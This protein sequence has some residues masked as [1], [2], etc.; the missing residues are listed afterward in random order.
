MNGV[1]SN[2]FGRTSMTP[3]PPVASSKPSSVSPR[4][5]SAVWPDPNHSPSRTRDPGNS[6]KGVGV[7]KR[8]GVSFIEPA[9]SGFTELTSVGTQPDKPAASAASKASRPI[10]DRRMMYPKVTQGRPPAKPNAAPARHLRPRPVRLGW[11][12]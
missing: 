8:P 10:D 9:N 3:R 1:R 12:A 4:R 2:D 6:P 5:P 7:V 11:R